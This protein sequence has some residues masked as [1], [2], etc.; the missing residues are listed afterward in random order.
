MVKKKKN[1]N[2]KN[3]FIDKKPGRANIDNRWLIEVSDTKE[4]EKDTARVRSNFNILP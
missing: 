3:G 1:R 4:G 2:R